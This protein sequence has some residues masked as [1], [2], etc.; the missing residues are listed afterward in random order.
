MSDFLSKVYSEN[1]EKIEHPRWSQ[2]SDTWERKVP[3]HLEIRWSEVS[4]E[5]KTAIYL[6]AKYALDSEPWIE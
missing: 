6:V 2:D 1:K 3:E 4:I 5:I